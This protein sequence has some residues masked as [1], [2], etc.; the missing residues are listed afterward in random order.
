MF[1]LTQAIEVLARTPHVL[2]SLLHGLSDGWTLR[3]YGEATFSPF[4]VVG[5]LLEADRHNWMP[6]LRLMLRDGTDTPFAAFDRYAM[7]ESS[8][9]KRLSELLDAFAQMRATN[10]LELES[11]HLTN[12]L[13]DRQG[14]HPDLGT[15]TVRQ[16]LATW[17][18]HDL[19]HTQQIVKAMAYQYRDAVGP[20]REYLSILPKPS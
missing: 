11:L 8:R 16:L 12:D 6:R 13:L 19:G 10:L 20:W 3:N 18:V 15:V 17:V 7:F 14:T 2:R 1:D 5:H 9:G 4:D